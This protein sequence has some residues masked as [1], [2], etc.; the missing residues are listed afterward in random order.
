MLSNSLT[1]DMGL[2]AGPVLLYA[3]VKHYFDRVKD[4]ESLGSDRLARQDEVLYDEVFHLI[5]SFM[6]ESTFHTVEELQ[7]FSNTQTP[8]S[9]STYLV[10]VVVPLTSC[11]EAAKYL[12]D[13]F[14]GEDKAREVVGGFKWW[15]ART[16]EGVDAQWIT[17]KKDWREAKKR[18]K[19]QQEQSTQSPPDQNVS[20]NGESNGTYEKYMD[21]MR[22]IL[23]IHGGG[24]YF[25]SVDQE[26]YSIQRH[27]RKT[28]GR[29]FAVNYRL[30]PQ[31]PFPCGLHDCLAAYLY[32]IQPP[33]D[34]K[35]S[36]IKP[37]HIVLA[38]DSAGGGMCL[39]LLQVIR[40]AGLHLPAGAVLI[41][42]WCDLTHSFPSIHTNTATDI[43]PPTGLSLHKPSI[44]WPPPS[45]DESV[46][47]HES[48]RQKVRRA[49]MG[50]LDQQPNNLKSEEPVTTSA[51]AP[52]VLAQDPPVGRGGALSRSP[53]GE[54]GPQVTLPK[55]EPGEGLRVDKQVHFYAQNN[56]L[57]HPLVSPALGYLGGLPPLFFIAGD[58]E[59]LRDEIIYTA[60]KAA[61]PHKYPVKESA[62]NLYPLLKDIDKRFPNPSSVHLQV[63]DGT[64]HVLPVL[65]S[66][67]TPAKFCF[68]A[69]AS[70]IKLV[71]GMPLTSPVSTS[72]ST[73][74]KL[75]RVNSLPTIP[76]TKS[77]E[78]S[79]G[80]LHPPTMSDRYASSL[81]APVSGSGSALTPP[82]GVSSV[83]RKQSIRRTMSIKITQVNRM[84]RR[85]TG[86]PEI[87]V[88]DNKL[89]SVTT[90]VLSPPERFA[91]E[92]TIYESIKDP[93]AFEMIRERVSTQGVI[94]PLEP[95]SDLEGLAVPDALIG[96]LS[97][98]I[99]K[100]YVD[101]EEVFQK[102]FKQTYISIKKTRKKKLEYIEK[103][104]RKRFGASSNGK[105]SPGGSQIRVREPQ[106]SVWG[107]AWALGDKYENPPPSSIVARRDTEEAL[108][109]AKVADQA[110]IEGSEINANN[111]WNIIMNA[112]TPPD[113]EVRERGRG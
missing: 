64:C 50:H 40:D 58:K 32:L 28:N 94:R 111:L 93:K 96:I 105:N 86:N 84:F 87:I 10:R 70:F 14:G 59:V 16:I 75:T 13:V 2:K 74:I 67:S 45:R 89:T 11:E 61:Y 25:G 99:I 17:A 31:Y 81:S 55:G 63:Y 46:R 62:R 66:F 71:A 72:D 49:L 54:S 22:C 112:L 108:K 24:Y 68:R 26:R 7:G 100:R 12:V 18:R 51:E 23:Y 30:A 83:R 47:F 48:L 69:I 95:E 90:E 109:L 15:Q 44:L 88:Q 43:L 91:G 102:K 110:M 82:S 101:N 106:S 20:T 1:R 4:R 107:Y 19:T 29:V 56:L 78:G 85:K 21:D 36:A 42:P 77:P 6:H 97:E 65:F 73:D 79:P 9:L 27:A 113:R 39:A 104:S 98:R 3:L 60:H 41:S 33:P 57:A 37:A 8:S 76:R 53:V 92:T 5:K 52:P 80:S 34:A 38:G 35:H 103:E